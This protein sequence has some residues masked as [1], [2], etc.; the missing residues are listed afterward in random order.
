MKSARKHR[1]CARTPLRAPL[2]LALAA[3]LGI[4]ALSDLARASTFQVTSNGDAGNGTCGTTCTLR[5]AVAA[6]DANA[7]ADTI[8]FA[9]T[10]SGDT[11]LVDVANK[12][13]IA[14]VGSDALTI[15]G[16]GA[17]HLTVSGG[18]VASNDNGG[19]FAFDGGNLTVSKISFAGG[20][21]LGAGGALSVVS[22]GDVK[23]S[24][25]TFVDNYAIANGG[26]LL[27]SASGDVRVEYSTLNGNRSVGTGSGG[28]F[29]AFG[30]HVVVVNSTLHGNSANALGGGFAVHGTLRMYNDTISNNS[31]ADGGGGFS[32]LGGNGTMNNTI[33]AGNTAPVSYG[34]EFHAGTFNYVSSD[35]AA[36]F[37]LIKGV[38][39]V[40]GTFTNS[41]S[42]FYQDPEL[43]P[44]AYNGGPTRTQALLPGSLAIDSGSP[45]GLNTTCTTF[46]QRQMPRPD[47]GNGDSVVRCDMGAFEVNFIDLDRIFANGF[48]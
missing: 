6:A 22:S 20:K 9:S 16:L 13:H 27:V 34:T 18:N 31:A 23:M 46:D 1:S 43:G 30:V 37:S 36:R 2:A 42:T 41:N 38:F 17:D 15:Q 32:L 24:R 47:D 29:Y 26:G 40:D 39:K 48:D 35:F 5:D 10:L 14:S 44:L 28:G 12:G 8:T 4:A 19:I 11:L 45:N 3:A 21:A 33:V 7:G 25:V